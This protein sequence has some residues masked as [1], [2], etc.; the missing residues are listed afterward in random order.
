MDSELSR[1]FLDGLFPEGSRR[2][3]TGE[4]APREMRF[5]V[6]RGKRGPRWIVP[7]HPAAGL[8]ALRHWRP[9]DAASR[10]KWTLLMAAYRAGVLGAVPGIARLAIGIPETADW[11]HL[12]WQG[13]SAPQPVVHVGTPSANQRLVASLVDP[14]TGVALAVAKVPVGANAQARILHEADLLERLAEEQPGVA[15]RL[16]FRNA[17]RG[18]ATEEAFRGQPTGRRL[19]ADHLAFLDRLRVAGGE[20]SL[21]HAVERLRPALDGLAPDVAAAISPVL[22][23]LD[24]PAPLPAVWLHGDFAPWNLFRQEGRLVACDWEN[25]EPRGLPLFDAM[26][27][28]WIQRY[29][30]SDRKS[31]CAM[32]ALRTQF[33]LTE[34]D[35]V[36]ISKFYR[37]ATIAKGGMEDPNYVKFLMGSLRDE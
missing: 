12:G 21:R 32:E 25:A 31:D 33:H 26:H 5:W 4:T 11:S 17:A 30:F 8:A 36:R 16:L 24:A 22:D 7:A 9:F 3:A 14:E 13:V 2:L 20:I 15:P 23:G 18:I 27:F 28:L 19:T 10:A 35:V 34:E 6:I 37:V 29:L 1:T